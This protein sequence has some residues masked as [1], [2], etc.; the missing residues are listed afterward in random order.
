MYPANITA[1]GC[2]VAPSGPS[3]HF[4]A[5]P[6]W[7]AVQNGLRLHCALAERVTLRAHGRDDGGR[8]LTCSPFH[9]LA[10]NDS[11]ARAELAAFATELQQ[12]G[13]TEGQNIRIDQRWAN[14]DVARLQ[15]LAEELVSMKTSNISGPKPHG[16]GL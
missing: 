13:W 8:E 3:S 2:H 7:S 10:E 14:G 11:Q 12:L 15:P 1:P 5:T 4:A 9:R 6:Q 16:M